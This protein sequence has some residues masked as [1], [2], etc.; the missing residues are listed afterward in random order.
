MTVE[1]RRLYFWLLAADPNSQKPYL[2]FGGN[3]EEE[4]RQRGLDLLGGVDFEIRPLRTRN[5]ATASSIIRGARLADT[6]SLHKASEKI[7][8]SRS[9]RRYLQNRGG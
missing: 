1:S 9:V 4:A 5:L 3:T 6:H 7:G 2:I 8:H